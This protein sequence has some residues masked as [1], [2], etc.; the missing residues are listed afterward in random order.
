MLQIF[1]VLFPRESMEPFALTLPRIVHALVL[2]QF[3]SSCL[4][5]SEV[6]VECSNSANC[7]AE[8]NAAIHG[9]ATAVIL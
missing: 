4:A 1:G 3:I 9:S 7:T 2:S 6:I 8:L 5:A